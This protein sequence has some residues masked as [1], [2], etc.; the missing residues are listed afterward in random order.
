M[1][2]FYSWV[3]D[4]GKRAEER[5]LVTEANFMYEEIQEQQD[6]SNAIGSAI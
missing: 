5:L 2:E 6:Y 1:E 3:N 4:E